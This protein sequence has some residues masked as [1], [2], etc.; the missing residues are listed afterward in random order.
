V[1]EAIREAAQRL[2]KVDAPTLKISIQV[3]DRP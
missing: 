3:E 1:A 2:A